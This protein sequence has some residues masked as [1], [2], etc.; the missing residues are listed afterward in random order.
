[1]NL[2]FRLIYLIFIFS[3]LFL[4]FGYEKSFAYPI[5]DSGGAYAV[6]S[7][8]LGSPPADCSI[9][10]AGS[11]NVC[12]PGG[13]SDCCSSGSPWTKY[14]AVCVNLDPESVTCSYVWVVASQVCATADKCVTSDGPYLRA[15]FC[16]CAT[17]GIYK[18]CC[19]NTGGGV[20][21]GACVQVSNDGIDPPWEGICPAGS[22]SVFGS[23]ASA[24]PVAATPTPTPAPCTNTCAT[25]ISPGSNCSY[26]SGGD[27][28]CQDQPNGNQDAYCWNCSG[29]APT[30]TPT[31]PT[32][33][34]TPTPTSVSCGSGQ[35]SCG[36]WG[37][38]PS[39]AQCNGSW[40][41]YYPPS[42]AGG[43][44][45][46]CEGIGATC[47]YGTTTTCCSGT[48]CALPPWPYAQ[49]TCEIPPN[50][51]SCQILQFGSQCV[52]AC[53]SGQSCISNSCVASQYIISGGFF[54]DTDQDGTKD[55]SE[56]YFTSAGGSFVLSLGN[57][58]QNASSGQFAY[59][60]LY[61]GTYSITGNAP[62][63]YS[64]TGS[65]PKTR[66][67]GPD[68]TA[69][70]GLRSNP[71]PAC[72][73]GSI[74]LNPSGGT[75]DPGTSKTLSVTSC[76]NVE[77]P[78][79]GSPPPPFSWNPDTNGNS[80]APTTSGQTDTPTSS[81]VT[82]TAPNCPTSTNIYT[83]RVTVGGSGGTVNYTT[84]ITVPATVSVTAHVRDVSSSGGCTS[85]S[86]NPYNNGGTGANLNLTNGGTVN[87]NQITNG[88]TGQASFTCLPQGNYTITLA[89][90]SGYSVIGTDV[91]P[92]VESPAGSNGLSFATSSNNQT[93]VFCIAPI[94]PWF[95]TDLGDV[96]FVNLSNPVPGG[97]LYASSDATYP[98][99]FYSSDSSADF[100]NAG[101]TFSS[102]RQWVINNEYSYNADTENRNGGMSYDFYKSKA[103]KDGV[104]VS[105]LN[106]DVPG[107]LDW[108][109]ITKSGVY[110]AT[111]DLTI[112]DAP[113]VGLFDTTNKT[114][115]VIL[116]SEDVVI[117]TNSLLI[118][119]NS[120]LLIVAAKG[121]ITIDETVGTA[122]LTSSASN[123]DGIYT[124]QGSIILESIGNG[125]ADGTTSDLRLN[126]GGA[127]V[128]NS[129]KPFSTVGT[130]SIQRNRSLCLDNL[131]RPSLFISSRPDFL[132]Q[133]TDFY[134]ISY[135][136][137]R[138]SNP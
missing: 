81:T 135:T 72:V 7:T 78:D 77:N 65:N 121:D 56:S 51:Q 44:G 116:V 85:S 14:Q 87:Q 57:Q 119:E 21:G 95:Q 112:A 55:A 6:C 42:C 137:W 48:T 115:V 27:A 66:T 32:A 114:R 28:W 29:G 5:D 76:T 52:D 39:C 107:S 138:E 19:N 105:P 47:G 124:A 62:S 46:G 31:G 67:I 91:S 113:P 132:V 10:Q 18:V 86:G 22:Y 133:M 75:A 41:P 37:C 64:I 92:A 122:T 33:T 69:W 110:E 127:L 15:G 24:C 108:D 117:S 61:S 23:D 74:S 59:T 89:V 50:C 123:L 58:T 102:V 70:F 129:L 103:L 101:V 2:R 84:S 136:K 111:G 45:S 68:A 25:S 8:C 71:P 53:P 16:S 83:P 3:F 94:D 26:N 34:S 96:R 134:K 30:S 38:I 98:G 90:P 4:N 120:G 126:V 60:G 12:T 100:G 104:T 109:E 1:M 9:S 79:N 13:S 54:T 11:C 73:P 82:W 125:C 130:G 63:G 118:P 49:G 106:E 20:A 43:G 36:S 80:P 17:G 40:P 128:A 93:A 35:Q 131:T 99:I 88:G 97:L